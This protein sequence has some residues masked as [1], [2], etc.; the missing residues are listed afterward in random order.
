MYHYWTI[1]YVP[2]IMRLDTVGVGVI[3]ASESGR[4][5]VGLKFIQTARDMFDIGGP[6][7]EFVRYL[8]E[9]AEDIN[10]HNDAD[11]PTQTHCWY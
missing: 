4:E 7:A 11:R 9:F 1:R 10:S 5:S 8:A 3:V 6:R 2:D